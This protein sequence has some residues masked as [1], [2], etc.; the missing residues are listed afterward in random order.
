MVDAVD[1]KSAVSNGVGVQ[2]PPGVQKRQSHMALSFFFASYCFLLLYLYF[3][4]NINVMRKSLLVITLLV[5]VSSFAANAESVPTTVA[6][7][8]AAAFLQLKGDSQL[9]LMKSPYE[10]FYLFDINGR[11]F[12]IVSADYRVQPILGY[13][14]GSSIDV[15]NLPSN[16]ASW[17]DGYDKQIRA[18]MEDASLPVHSGWQEQGMAKSGVDGYDSIV[19]PLL[20]TIWDQA[21][22]YNDLCPT[23]V[24]DRTL[25][26][27]VA[28]A[29]AQIM[30]YWNWPDT[31][32]GQHSYST[33]RFGV[34]SANFE[35]AYDWANMPTE[36][37][38]S[39]SSAQV[40]A[41]ATLMYHCGISVDMHYG[42]IVD[43]GSGAYDIMNDRGFNYPCAENALR[44]YFKYSPGLAGVLR[45]Y[46][47]SEEWE[48]MMKNEIDHRRP[49][50]YSGADPSG[51]HEFV[52]DG[53]DTNGFF[54][55]NW[56]YGGSG[57]GYFTLEALD[58]L[59]FNFSYN[60]HAVIGIVPDTLYGSSSSCTVSAA[61]SDT[62]NGSVSGGGTYNYRDTVMLSASPANGYRFLRWSNGVSVNPYPILA[63]DVSITA[64][65]TKTLAEDG[66]VLSYTGTNTSQ[67]GV[68]NVNTSTRIGIKL[69]AYCLAGHKYLTAVDLFHY[70]G[71]YVIYVHSGGDDAPGP[72]VYTQP[73]A[74]RAARMSWN[75]IQFETPVPIDTNQNLWITVRF[76]NEDQLSFLGAP[77]LR[78]PDG[79][80]IS[81]DNGI[82]W[83]H[84]NQVQNPSRWNDTTICWFIRCVTSSD[85]IVDTQLSPSA[86][87]NLP[88]QCNIGDTV[89]VELLHSTVST[90][91]WDCHDA[92]FYSTFSDSAFLVWNNV[93][94][95]VVEARIESPV[96]STV[97]VDTILAVDCVTP[98]STYPYVINYVEDDEPLR[99]CWQTV[100]YGNREGYYHLAVDYYSGIVFDET[101]DRYISPLFDLS[102]DG[103]M[104]LEVKHITPSGSLATVEISQGGG[105]DSSDFTTIYTLPITDT[106]A[107]TTQPIDLS[108]YYQG[109]L[110]RIALRF[111]KEVGA[112]NPTIGILGLRIWENLGIDDV[113]GSSLAVYPN[114]ARCSVSVNLPYA[115]GTLT[116]FD[117]TG[118]QKMQRQTTSTEVTIDVNALPQGVYMLQYTSQRGT[119]TTRF[120]VQ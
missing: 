31:G 97:V 111:R 59:E 32:V 100:T 74:I 39:S 25:T 18:A 11:G 38:F 37:T 40:A 57:D 120:V 14:L 105:I 68:F 17:L 73:G 27:C 35:T 104:M 42:D 2:V 55:F 95:H 22:L 6:A 58:P 65:F 44:T 26:G 69:P 103:T 81:T 88:D 61:S 13:S 7:R 67:Q 89:E 9:K 29:M 78:I 86:F 87:I 20:T 8:K 82:S 24:L 47:T 23:T 34:L 76:L 75:R 85:S 119:S 83:Q 115:H 80:W 12:V 3:Q 30:N 116:L 15:D 77:N 1:S 106:I 72:V 50:L 49:I 101:D 112:S 113:K 94:R 36:L 117:V 16:C 108:Q 53:Y 98:V 114:P 91:E 118:R 45:I 33:D 64:T 79:N 109:N 102:G 46:F 63:H 92:D 93:G 10:T 70:L 62:S 99:V 66:E 54:H 71:E 56:G 4:I 107:A 19:G 28:T 84:L 21:P 41:V 48:A 51:G 96:G 5:L 52:C 43:G 60:Q 90:V 110:V